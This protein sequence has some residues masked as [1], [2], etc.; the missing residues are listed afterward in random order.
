[1]IR[2]LLDKFLLIPANNKKFDLKEYMATIESGKWYDKFV[3]GISEH[4]KDFLVVNPVEQ[5][6]A[7]YFGG[8]GSGKS[9]GMEFSVVTRFLSNSE[10]DV[11]ILMDPQKG[12]TDYKTLFPYR[13]N[14]ALALNDATK[15]IALVDMLYEEC[16]ARK[17]AFS[18]V[19][20]NNGFEYERIMRK[21]NPNYRL[22]RIFV[23]FEEFHAVIN[24]EA[25]KFAYKCDTEGTA[26]YKFKQLLKISRSYLFFF[27]AANQ[28]ASSDDTPS[29]LKA[30]ITT[31]LG[32]RV[33]N[34]G[35]AAVANL[36]QAA[37]ISSN[38]RGRCVTEN[39]FMQFPF[40]PDDTAEFLLKKYHRPLKAEMMKYAVSDFHKAL[41]GEG[42]EGLVLIK[43]FKEIL[44][45]LYAVSPIDVC[46]RYLNTF[47]FSVEK[48]TNSALAVQLVATRDD[49]KFAVMCV[50]Q[51]NQTTAKGIEAF[52]YGAEI[53]GCNEA[54]VMSN[55]TISSS[56]SNDA[57][58]NKFET[59]L[60]VDGEDLSRISEVLDNQSKLE[61]AGKFEVLYNKLPLARKQPAALEVD[62]EDSDDDDDSIPDF[63][64]IREKMRRGE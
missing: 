16:M 29:A 13:E 14:V 51:R 12:M 56:V 46:M 20:A 17:E 59:C 2:A 35:D 21:K 15:I 47:G 27:A 18:K 6:G 42:N 28:R 61:I 38:L 26:A 48:P 23:C 1:M 64:A 25:L 9:K 31:M 11:Y 44:V 3:Y 8:M 45:Q 58:K 62:E 52:H 30:G 32:F 22:A 39:G 54:I 24:S 33:N 5:P 49:R 34:P 63:Q 60:I 37:D 55:E 36:P 43:P 19:Q 41:E 7:L 10:H 50:T 40:L 4:E 53:L 57:T